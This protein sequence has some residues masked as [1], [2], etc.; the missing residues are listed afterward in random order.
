MMFGWHNWKITF[1][2][3]SFKETSS[4]RLSF[5][6]FFPPTFK[7]NISFNLLLLHKD[8]VTDIYMVGLRICEV[9]LT[10]V[11]LLYYSRF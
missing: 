2:I 9:N 11:Q 5:S 10:N 8:A 1:F 7:H 6:F 4:I 3:E